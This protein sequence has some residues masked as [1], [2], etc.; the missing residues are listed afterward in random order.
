MSAQSCAGRRGRDP[1]DAQP[2]RNL[3]FSEAMSAWIFFPIALRRSSASAGE[4]PATFFAI[5][6][7]LL[8][9]DRRSRR[10]RSVISFSR[11]SGYVTGSWPALR[12]A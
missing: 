6:M 12:R 4:K 7:L 2:S 3:L 9:V 5:S 8:L 11:G 1:F 10:C